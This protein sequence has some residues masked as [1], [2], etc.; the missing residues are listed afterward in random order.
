[1][2]APDPERLAW[3]KEPALPVTV[4]TG[5][6]GSGKTTLLRRLLSGGRA[7]DTAVIVNEWGEV[8]LDH[9]L[10]ESAEEDTVLL[11]GGCLCCSLRGDLVDTLMR[12]MERRYRGEVPAFRRVVVETSG[13]ADPLPIVQSFMTDPLRLSR[14]RLGGLVTVVDALLGL[15]TLQ[16]HAVSGDQ[17]ALADRIVISKADLAPAEAIQ[18]LSEGLADRNPGA[19]VTRAD[20]GAVA[21]NF[22]FADHGD[23]ATRP[24]AWR[25]RSDAKETAG[26]DSFCLTLEQPVEWPCFRAF[27]ERLIAQRGG[28]I[29]RLKG[30]VNALGSDRPILINGAQHLFHAPEALDTWPD[31]PR[32]TTLVFITR[33]LGKRVVSQELQA[34]LSCA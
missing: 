34:A 30:L 18:D 5:F 14:Y 9:H 28:E 23:S 16:S 4:L 6:L 1:M 22:F 17:V 15:E 25:R 26:P 31:G 2:K 11:S 19:A 33:G 24:D 12:L 10:I 7:K 32:I 8:G 29:L 3:V 21:W 13:L 27:L 20:H